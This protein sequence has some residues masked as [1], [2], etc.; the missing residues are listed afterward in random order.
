[1][2][3]KDTESPFFKTEIQVQWGEMDAAQHVNNVNYLRWA[4]TARI[5][6]FEKL[7]VLDLDFKILGIIL[8]WQDCKYI[9]PI[10]FPDTAILTYDITSVFNDR[11]HGECKIYSKTNNKIAAISKSTVMAY[12]Y[13]KL[14]KAEIPT[15]W[16]EQI[17]SVY[18]KQI[19]DLG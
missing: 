19:I 7:N 15:E 18:G 13:N 10:K 4:E 8:A 17:I 5:G 2:K 14:A 11:I 1:M 6:F 16:K 3:N 9:F 12:D